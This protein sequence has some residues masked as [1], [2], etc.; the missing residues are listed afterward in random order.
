MKTFPDKTITPERWR[1]IEEIYHAALDRAPGERATFLAGLSGTD[2]EVCREVEWLLAE[3]VASRDGILDRPLVV[4]P[5]RVELTAPI[6]QGSAL[7]PGSQ[8][9]PYRIEASVGKGGMGEV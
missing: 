8:L 3:D 6:N 4:P 7:T 5:I 1:R 2:A 9:G